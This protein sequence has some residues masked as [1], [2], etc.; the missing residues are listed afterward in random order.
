MRCGVSASVRFATLR[1]AIPAR[2]EKLNWV[3][4]GV[5]DEDLPPA[6]SADDVVAERHPGRAQ[7]IHERRDV[8]DLDYEAVPAARRRLAPVRHR[9][10]GRAGRA[11]EPQLQI[12]SLNRRERGKHL[13]QSR[14]AQLADVEIERTLYVGDDVS[15]RSHQCPPP[16]SRYASRPCSPPSRPKPDSL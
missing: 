1:S 14:E 4:V 10:R 16:R 15:H 11:C 2:L 3:A 12:L 5:V 6:G 7:P 8:V 9:T 13:L